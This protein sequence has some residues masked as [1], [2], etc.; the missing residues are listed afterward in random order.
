[1]LRA[2]MLTLLTWLF[3]S[4]LVDTVAD[5]GDPEAAVKEV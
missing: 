5:R 2:V 4:H 3:L 1:M